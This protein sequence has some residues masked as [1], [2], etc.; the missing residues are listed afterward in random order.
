MKVLISSYEYKNKASVKI[1]LVDKE[2]GI[3]DVDVFI[4]EVTSPEEETV[5]FGFRPDEGLLL[6]KLIAEAMNKAIGSYEVDLDL[7]VYENA[8]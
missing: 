4:L 5:A 8:L 2:P 6:I 1:Y 7:S 3:P